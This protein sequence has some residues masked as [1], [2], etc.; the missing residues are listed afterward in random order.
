MTG[1]FHIVYNSD[2][3]YL[4]PT[5]VSAAREIYHAADPSRIVIDVLDCGIKATNWDRMKSRL[6]RIFPNL[7]GC[8]RHAV[9][10]KRISKFQSWRG[11]VA[12]YARILTPEVLRDEDMCLF[13]DGDTLFISD[14]LELQG[15]YDSKYWIQGSVDDHDSSRAKMFESYG[16]TM[17]DDYVCCGLMLMNLCALRESGFVDKC[18]DFLAKYPVLKCVDQEA[19]NTVAHGH[20]SCLDPEWGVFNCLAFLRV[21]RPKCLHY[22]CGKPW[23]LAFPW[24]RCLYDMEH[25]WFAYAR[26][27]LGL[28]WCDFN[29]IS[30]AKYYRIVLVTLFVSLIRCVRRN[31]KWMHAYFYDGRIWRQLRDQF[32]F[33]KEA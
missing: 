2:D 32:P 15:K 22:V 28:S 13:A 6:L 10:M 14:P 25:A 16:L 12:T 11:S 18:F 24:T 21:K 9:D 3:N 23:Q 8:V 17:P 29:E 7:G 33:Y 27:L 1:T 19:I 26:K 31:K 30:I 4:M 20:M 5:F